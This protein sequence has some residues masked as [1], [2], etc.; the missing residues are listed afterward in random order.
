MKMIRLFLVAVTA[1]SLLSSCGSAGSRPVPA[2]TRAPVVIQRVEPDYPT[3]LRAAGVQGL[4]ELR[5]TVPKE[6]GVL[7]NPRVVRSDD[8]R[9]DRLALEAIS[10]WV[11]APGMQDGKAVDVEFTT[12]MRFSL[13]R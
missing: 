7:R 5:G 12:T 11:W 3:E 1:A 10:H 13:N 4:V 6:G 9:L 8:P 2:G